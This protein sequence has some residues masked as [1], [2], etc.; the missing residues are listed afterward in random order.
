MGQSKQC[1]NLVPAMAQ[2]HPTAI[3]EADARI[4][5]GTRVLN[6]AHVERGASIGDECIIGE[7]TYVAG[8][9]RIG[10]RVKIDPMAY[11]CGTVIIE[12]GVLVSAS[13]IFTDNKFSRAAFPDLKTLRSPERDEHTQLTLVR[14]GATVGAGCVIGNDLE[15]GRW[16]MVG[17]GSIVTESVPDFHL[18]VGSPARTVG[19]VCKCGLL[20]HM[21]SDSDNGSYKCDC[22]LQYQISD[23]VVNE[24]PVALG[25]RQVVRHLQFAT[26]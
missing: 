18:V 17:M 8:D 19:A 2:I 15:I 6:H 13:A 16:A 20:F 23:R 25:K 4:G 26:A 10:N 9:A 5:K 14:E 21:F 7:K 24:M 12:D 11:I 22:G 1:T 3:V